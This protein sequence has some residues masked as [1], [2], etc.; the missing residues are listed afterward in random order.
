H[1]HNDTPYCLMDI[2]VT[3][4]LFDLFPKE[5]LSE[6]STASL[7]SRYATDTVAHAKQSLTIGFADYETSQILQCSMAAPVAEVDRFFM[8]ADGQL[9]SRGH[10]LYRGDLF[11]METE[12][13]GD[14]LSDLPSGWLPDIKGD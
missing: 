3:K 6:I 8:N 11:R 14:P 7:V 4:E 9:L 5:E 2:Y 10:Y 12:H 1:S 13:M